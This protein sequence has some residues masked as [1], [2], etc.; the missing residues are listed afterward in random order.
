MNSTTENT[1]IDDILADIHD[2]QE[3]IEE[4]LNDLVGAPVQNECDYETTDTSDADIS[5]DTIKYVPTSLSNNNIF[6]AIS[7]ILRFRSDY[8]SVGLAT[9]YRNEDL[10]IIQK[11]ALGMLLAGTFS[12]VVLNLMG[13]QYIMSLIAISAIIY[14][15][16]I[17]KK[18]RDAFPLLKPFATF[19]STGS[20]DLLKIIKY[21]LLL[22]LVDKD[23]IWPLFSVF[24]TNLLQTITFSSLWQLNVLLGLMS[25]IFL[26]GFTLYLIIHVIEEQKNKNNTSAINKFFSGQAVEILAISLLAL[27]FIQNTYLPRLLL[28][29]LIFL[30]QLYHTKSLSTHETMPRAEVMRN[31]AILGLITLGFVPILISLHSL[32]S[33]GFMTILGLIG[34]TICSLF[35]SN[36]TKHT[37]AIAAN[38]HASA[39]KAFYQYYLTGFFTFLGLYIHQPLAF[40]TPY[41]NIFGIISILCAFLTIMSKLGP[42][43]EEKNISNTLVG[44]VIQNSLNILLPT[45]TLGI[46]CY[47]FFLTNSLLSTAFFTSLSGFMI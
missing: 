13:R 20:K 5:F 18:N 30:V 23:A 25:D 17:N 29:S 47:N 21:L 26:V 9:Y 12:A 14:G 15:Y 24:N 46:I 1:M 3:H 16:C 19:D 7:L 8:K 36:I 11:M 43:S 38:P 45:I 41:A 33:A 10:S 32:N 40:L 34:Y 39:Y 28:T 2:T 4:E 35:A 44:R 22:Q 42:I 6:S 37:I 27:C 31:L